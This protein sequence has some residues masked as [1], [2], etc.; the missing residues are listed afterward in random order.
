MNNTRLKKIISN[1][2]GQLLGA[3][4]TDGWSVRMNGR[5]VAITIRGPTGMLKRNVSH[6][7]SLLKK[8]FH[9]DL[10]NIGKREGIG[11]VISYPLIQRIKAFRAVRLTRKRGKRQAL[12]YALKKQE[13]ETASNKKRAQFRQG[14]NKE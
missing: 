14:V 11:T 2:L 5:Q 13:E 10:K 12:K 7:G 4:E 3:N 1:Y 6:P 9:D 8:S